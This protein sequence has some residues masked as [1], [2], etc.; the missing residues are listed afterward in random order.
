MKYV[1]D[2]NC[3]V[4]GDYDYIAFRCDYVGLYYRVVMIRIQLDY[5][6]LV[7]K[8]HDYDYSIFVIDYNRL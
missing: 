1:I 2:C 7:S 4:V 5:N 8:I 6:Y 3:L